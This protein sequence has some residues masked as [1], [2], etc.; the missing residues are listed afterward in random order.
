MPPLRRGVVLQRRWTDADGEKVGLWLACGILLSIC[1]FA[2]LL[3]A[4][5]LFLNNPLRRYRVLR[6]KEKDKDRRI[7]T[8]TSKVDDLNKTIS[9]SEREVRNER[10]RV[11]QTMDAMGNYRRDIADKNIIIA[12]KEGRIAGL[13]PF[14]EEANRLRPAVGQKDDQIRDLR[15]QLDQMTQDRDQEQRAKEESNRRLAFVTAQVAE[16]QTRGGFD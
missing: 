12:Q 8:L 14:E 15:H 16:F 1:F 11:Q 5:N 3:A 9:Q 2:I 6:K 4:F 10:G 7:S 13:L